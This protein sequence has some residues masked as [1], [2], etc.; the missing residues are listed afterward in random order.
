MSRHAATPTAPSTELPTWINAKATAQTNRANAARQANTRRRFVDPTTCERD[1]S[2]AE[3]EFLLAMHEY[4][5]TSGR[6][7]PTWSEVLEVLQGLG[8]EKVEAA[9][10]IGHLDRAT[11]G[12]PA[13][14]RSG[15]R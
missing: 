7:F 12:R 3:A 1:E 14:A 6:M 11:G 8:Y 10:P 2:A 4:K 15:A 9:V 13:M 5:R